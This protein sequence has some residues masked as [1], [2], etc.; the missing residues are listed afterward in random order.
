MIQL[1]D[2]T[3]LMARRSNRYKKGGDTM[4]DYPLLDHLDSWSRAALISYLFSY[5]LAHNLELGVFEAW[6]TGGQA[7]DPWADTIRR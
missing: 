1:A 5:A 6:N 2:L 4:K 7:F 3:R